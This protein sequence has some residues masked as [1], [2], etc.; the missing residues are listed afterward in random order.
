MKAVIFNGALKNKNQQITFQEIIEEELAYVG[1]ETESLM[2]NQIDIKTCIGCFKCWDTTPGI[3][4]GVKG[5]SGEEIK[6]KVVNSDLLVFLT[7]L[8]FGGYSSELKKIL[9]RLLGILQPGVVRKKKE[10]HHLKRY[11]K[12]PSILAIATTDE[13]EEEE[14]K[15]FKHLQDRFCI[16]FHPPNHATEVFLINEDENLVRLG[17]K[18]LLA[19]MELR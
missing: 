16:N 9:E 6:K 4:S 19:E 15:L 18:Q 11:D 1:M 2:L 17:I 10:T 3:C 7:P 14:V 12:Y 5:D 13:R 8:T